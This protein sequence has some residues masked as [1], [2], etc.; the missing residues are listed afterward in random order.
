MPRE[1]REFL[2][3]IENGG[4]EHYAHGWHSWIYRNPHNRTCRFCGLN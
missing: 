4:Y 1:L 2:L 3:W